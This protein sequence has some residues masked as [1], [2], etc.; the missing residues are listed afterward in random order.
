MLAINL[1][2]ILKF[3]WEVDSTIFKANQIGY[4]KISKSSH[5]ALMTEIMELCNETRCFNYWSKKTRSS[6]E[7]VLEEYAD[8][9]SFLLSNG[10]Q[11]YG[12]EIDTVIQIR[13]YSKTTDNQVLVNKFLEV[14]HLFD[15]MSDLLSCIKLI[16]SFIELGYLLGYDY[17]TLALAHKRK[18]DKVINQQK[19]KMQEI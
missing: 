5:L 14:I 10:I 19:E 2:E 11:G 12:L 16:E 8:A 4:Q 3:Q 1:S 13:F 6:D 18:C 9:L 15:N 7:V 17:D